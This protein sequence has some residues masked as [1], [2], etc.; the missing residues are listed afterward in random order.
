MLPTKR[1]DSRLLSSREVKSN[2]NQKNP[3][4][5][6]VNKTTT[7]DYEASL[8]EH[9]TTYSKSNEEGN[10]MMLAFSLQQLR[11][12]AA[13]MNYMYKNNASRNEGAKKRKRLALRLIQSNFQDRE[14][15]R[16]ASRFVAVANG[17]ADNENKKISCSLRA[18]Q[19][20]NGRNWLDKF[21]MVWRSKLED[22]TPMA[23][24]KRQYTL[25]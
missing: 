2:Q 9:G 6:D 25:R 21:S 20:T 17:R 14:I 11:Q 22:Q 7:V 19:S 10:Q 5:D 8:R 18:L 12:K 1:F 15:G 23:S 3:D 13:K 24:K 16:V 4:D